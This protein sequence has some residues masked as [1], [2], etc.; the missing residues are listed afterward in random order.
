MPEDEQLAEKIEKAKL[1]EVDEVLPAQSQSAA[2]V[3]SLPPQ[4]DQITRLGAG[5]I[6]TVYRARNIH[7]KRMVAVKLLKNDKILS[8]DFERFKREAVA[9]GSFSHANAV[10]VL[11]FGVWEDTPYLVMEYVEGQSL[12]SILASG[13]SISEEMAIS[14]ATDVCKALVE[15]HGAGVVHRDIKPSNIIVRQNNDGTYTAKVLDFGLARLVDVQVSQELTA[16]GDVIGTPLYMSPEQFQSFPTDARSDIYSLGAVMYECLSGR[17]PHKG[18]SIYQTMYKCINEKPKPI[19]DRKHKI[20]SKL[21]SI[22][23]RCLEK[24]PFDRY[25]NASELLQDLGNFTSGR[26]LS[27]RLWIKS[28]TRRT[29]LIAA[30]TVALLGAIGTALLL[31]QNAGSPFLP[32][33]APQAVPDDKLL[34]PEIGW[35]RYDLRGQ[36][37]LNIASLGQ[38]QDEFEKALELAPDNKHKLISLQKIALVQHLRGE[39]EAEKQTDATISALNKRGMGS[40]ADV[41]ALK[42]ALPLLST[43]PNSA[44]IKQIDGLGADVVSA[45]TE[46]NR[47]YSAP[48]AIDLIDAALPPLTR[49]LGPNSK[50][51][52]E[53]L[54]QKVASLQQEKNYSQAQALAQSA[55]DSLQPH[56]PAD[57]LAVNAIR[58]RLANSLNADMPRGFGGAESI[59]NA[60]NAEAHAKNVISNLSASTLPAAKSLIAQAHL[61]RGV[62]LWHQFLNEEVNAGNTGPNVKMNLNSPLEQAAEQELRSGLSSITDEA[63]SAALVSSVDAFGLILQSKESSDKATEIMGLYAKSVGANSPLLRADYL[64]ALGEF[65]FNLN[66]RTRLYGATDGAPQAKTPAELAEQYFGEALGIRQHLLPPESRPVVD[67]LM[68]MCMLAD[69]LGWYGGDRHASE[70]EA[71]TLQQI[72]LLQRGGYGTDR[73]ASWAYIPDMNVPLVQLAYVYYSVGDRRNAQKYFDQVIATMKYQREH[74]GSVVANAVNDHFRKMARGLKNPLEHKEIMRIVNGN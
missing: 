4:Y 8:H 49:A 30:L 38:A 17:T 11:D 37:A 74:N 69:R 55:L 44:Q 7:T 19:A 54:G 24:D 21:E 34:M 2:T 63:D 47:Q 65:Y 42:K 31:R 62:S 1:K 73:A 53:L 22:V 15:A 25:Q 50:V 67:S 27:L 13:K 52:C 58:L 43:K 20:S 33:K 70:N 16:T 9:A 5:A 28:R 59:T 56:A 72:A 60:A 3:P 71:L 39:S 48:D 40:G 57:D 26:S 68:R 41:S 45:A 32:R 66:Q 29:I 10:G 23:F 36:Y 64:H 46:L 61:A 18:E 35:D 51:V 12:D 6:G 14:I